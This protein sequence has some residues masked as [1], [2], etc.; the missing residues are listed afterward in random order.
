M[1]N[2]TQVGNVQAAAQYRVNGPAALKYFFRWIRNPVSLEGSSNVPKMKMAVGGPEFHTR[3]EEM[4]ADPTGRRILAD[5]PDLGLA[6]ADDGLAD[7]PQGSLGRSYH[8]HANVEGAVPGYLLA[9][10]IYRGD[11]Y[12]KLDWNEDMKY[13]LYR[14]SNTHDLIHMLCG[15]GTDL[16]GESL[17]I[18]YSMG[19]EAMDT[20]KARRMARLWVYISWVMMSPS[21]GFRKYQAYSMEAFERGVATRNTRAVHTIYFEEMLPLPVDEVRRQLGVPPKRESFDTADWTLSWLGN[22]IATGYRS[23]DDGA[24]QRLAWMDSLVAAGIPVKTLVNLKDSTL[25]QML[26]SAE[27]GAGPEELRA[28]AGMA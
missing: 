18:S 21:V 26:R 3:V 7:L 25:D 12:D 6:L 2:S 16:A 14:M 23:S 4:R 8:A 19:L 17:T 24:G 5:R 11:N 9:G 15:Y 1:T 22:K 10:Q 27:K 13:L 20:R 28:M